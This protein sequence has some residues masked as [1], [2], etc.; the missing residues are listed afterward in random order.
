MEI[1][2]GIEIDRNG[3]TGGR[4]AGDQERFREFDF[5]FGLGLTAL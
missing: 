1:V 3:D 2:F 5:A 4:A